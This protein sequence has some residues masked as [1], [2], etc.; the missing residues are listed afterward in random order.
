MPLLPSVMLRTEWPR[1]AGEAFPAIMTTSARH[2]RA[3]GFPAPLQ[4][5]VKEVSD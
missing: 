3:G 5:F 4:A 1:L 2:E